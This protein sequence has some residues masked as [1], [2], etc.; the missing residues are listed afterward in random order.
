MAKI[1]PTM[2]SKA[3]RQFAALPVRVAAAG[4]VEIMLLT[5]R[6]TR[7]W[8]IPKGWPMSGLSASRA[9]SREA[10]EEAG[11]EGVVDSDIPFG[12]YSY[13]KRLKDG[14]CRTIEVDVFLF[15]VSRQR[16]NWPEKRQRRTCWYDAATASSLVNEPELA[17]LLLRF[18]SQPP[19]PS[20]K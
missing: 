6:G 14:V 18:D 5:S 2:S 20:S 15:K 4:H 16:K 1:G 13:Q 8:V 7:R 9:A 17:D 11:L 12:R 3:V 10:F 19:L